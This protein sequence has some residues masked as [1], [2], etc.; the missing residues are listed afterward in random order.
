M[1]HHYLFL[2][3]LPRLLFHFPPFREEAREPQQEPAFPSFVQFSLQRAS[4]QQRAVLPR[5]PP[6]VSTGGTE[7]PSTPACVLICLGLSCKLV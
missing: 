2:S 6:E 7:G 3:F 1:N 4:A 5:V